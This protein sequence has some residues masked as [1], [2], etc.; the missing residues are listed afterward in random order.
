V[1]TRHKALETPRKKA[2]FRLRFLTRTRVKSIGCSRKEPQLMSDS[3]RVPSRPLKDG[4]T[5]APLEKGLTSS[6]LATAL[7]RPATVT[8]GA[9]S[10]PAT[11]P[12]APPSD[13]K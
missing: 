5:S 13:A 10:P 8:P 6:A 1:E 2:S 4:L 3:R 11:A 9:S 12:Q 7:N